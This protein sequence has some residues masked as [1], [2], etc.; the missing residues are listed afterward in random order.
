MKYRKK[1]TEVE[2]IQWTGENWLA[3][4]EFFGGLVTLNSLSSVVVDTLDGFEMH[5]EPY[6]W[7]VCDENGQFQAVESRMFFELYQAA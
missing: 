1:S 2:A 6:D 4:A 7:I 3:I 5:A